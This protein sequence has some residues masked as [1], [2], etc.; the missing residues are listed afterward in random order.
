M[1][2]FGAG[3]NAG[4]KDSASWAL[5]AATD[6]KRVTIGA[7]SGSASTNDM[8]D[9]D[10]HLENGPEEH[11]ARIGGSFVPIFLDGRQQPTHES[12]RRLNRVFASGVG[13]GDLRRDG[14]AHP[15]FVCRPRRRR[16]HRP[17]QRPSRGNTAPYVHGRSCLEQ[18]I[19]EQIVSPN[20]I[21]ASRLKMTLKAALHARS[22]RDLAA[23]PRPGDL[24]L[25]EVYSTD[26]NKL[27][28]SGHVALELL[29]ANEVPVTLKL[30]RQ[31][32]IRLQGAQ[33]GPPAGLAFRRGKHAGGG[34]P[35]S[36]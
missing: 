19:R 22:P 33:S 10:T 29:Q 6:L 5:K 15:D 35:F 27:V 9:I 31:L 8:G 16:Q 4:L 17:A 11:M 12:C 7:V 1:K 25:I 14:A 26:Y 34:L 23:E 24:L 18:V 30:R 32:D 21:I 20:L 13:G 36:C 28:C 3:L 2:A